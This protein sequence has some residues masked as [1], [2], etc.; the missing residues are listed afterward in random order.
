MPNENISTRNY[1]KE[2]IFTP[3][4]SARDVL[5][6]T[7]YCDSSS[8]EMTRGNGNGMEEI[9]HLSSTK[10]Q[11]KNKFTTKGYIFQLNEIE[12]KPDIGESK[13]NISRNDRV[14]N[15]SSYES[16]QFDVTTE[17]SRNSTEDTESCRKYDLQLL[18]QHVK[19]KFIERMPPKHCMCFLNEELEELETKCRKPENK[20]ENVEKELLYSKKE[21]FRKPVNFEERHKCGSKSDYEL[22]T[23]RNDRSEKATNAKN[24][25][26]QLQ[27]ATEL[28]CDLSRENRDLKETLKKLK[29]QTEFGYVLLKEEMQFNRELEMAKIHRQL[30]DLKYELR[31][32]KRLRAINDRAL[33][34]L[35]KQ[36]AWMSISSIHNHFTGHFF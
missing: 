17:E 14:T 33:D 35:T 20:L 8:E 10:C 9:Y 26:E 18:R 4:S 12:Q 31:A 27:R 2:K 22:Q 7:S 21:V 6:G 5:E 19:N 11:E 36:F 30:T 16:S 32:E 29:H 1:W 25:T 34:L 15:S 24:L 13:V 3:L 28:I 23:L